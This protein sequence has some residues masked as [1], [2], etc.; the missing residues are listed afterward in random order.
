[1]RH[2]TRITFVFFLSIFSLWASAEEIEFAQ[3]DRIEIPVGIYITSLYA[4]DIPEKKFTVSAWIWS[5]F[6]PAK[7]PDDYRF[8]NK[9]EITNARSWSIIE[10]ENFTIKNADGTLHSMTKFTAEINQDWD[11]KYF[12]FD[13]QS[14]T[15]NI[16]SIELD[17]TQI[18]FVPDMKNSRVSDELELSGWHVSP[19]DIRS[20]DYKYP[21]T[22]GIQSGAQGIYPRMSFIVPIERNGTRIFWTYFLGFFVSYIIICILYF[23]T[24]ELIESRIGLIMTALF[25]CVGNKYTVDL[26][27]PSNDVFTLSDLIQVASF[28]IVGVGLLSSVLIVVLVKKGAQTL[29]QRIDFFITWA[30]TLGYPAAILIG[31]LMA[32]SVL[33]AQG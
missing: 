24:G 21:T 26:L 29:A 12:P 7:L 4:L 32:P 22:F 5:T 25:A 16:E 1:M 11:V 23:F 31:V 10:N 33:A 17:S 18:K 28:I 15:I 2:L 3:E 30:V 20:F 14:I 19:I 27:L 9:I 13:R 6:D 8:Y